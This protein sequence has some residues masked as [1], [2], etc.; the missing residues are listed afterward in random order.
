[1]STEFSEEFRQLATTLWE[2]LLGVAPGVFLLLLGV[3]LAYLVAKK[4]ALRTLVGFA[5]RS[6]V[7]WDDIL[8]EQR[9]FHR[10]VPLAPLLVL[11]W[12]VRFLPE[13]PQGIVELVETL[14]LSL[15]VLVTVRSFSA[16]L[17][18]TNEI[19]RR[20]SP[21]AE[22]PIKGY[23]QVVQVIS[24]IIAGLLIVSFLV[25]KSPLILL[26]GLG[27]MTAVLLLIFRDSLLSL[28]AGVQLTQNDSIRVGDWIEMPQ[29]GA[30]GDVIEV[31]LNAV[32]VQNWDRTFSMI[33]TH[34]F[35][36][37]SFKNWRG[38]TESG[39][40]RIKRP[41]H[42]DM[43]SI[44]F[45]TDEEVQNLRKIRVLRKY[46]DEKLAEI[47]TYNEC[48]VPPEFIGE[49]VNVRKLTNVGTFRA[50]ITAYLREHKGIRQDMIFLIRQLEPS[51]KGLPIEIY[52]F[53]ND[54]RWVFYEGIQAD[55]FDHL[56]S[57]VPK[58]GLRVFQE[59]TG[60][61][62]AAALSRGSS[63]AAP[64]LPAEGAPQKVL[65]EQ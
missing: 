23:I 5:E 47:T 58:F 18:S 35:L 64:S 59:P 15:V 65:A 28:V 22:R 7:K 34:K 27:A 36:E 60:L 25:G 24:Y 17:S 4:V 1:M 43:N 14:T 29:F 61:D 39:G 37:H 55:I 51:P 50:Y 56:L 48:E 54:I 40:R 19:Y 45:L 3:W 11:Q 20:Y 52:V 8:V 16:L 44:R 6:R 30:D 9:V 32:T 26:S 42:L 57:V 41:I 46:I 10:L 63:T 53:C 33:P 62:F 38:M 2:S 49:E 31:A 21:T 12:G 13:L